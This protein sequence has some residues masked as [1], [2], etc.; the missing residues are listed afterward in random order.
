M[1]TYIEQLK[2]KYS[3]P[4]QAY[5]SYALS[6]TL[7]HH[8]ILSEN[9]PQEVKEIL[10]I[11]QILNNYCEN[12]IEQ[13]FPKELHE[14]FGFSDKQH[15]IDFIFTNQNFEKLHFLQISYDFRN[16]VLNGEYQKNLIEKSQNITWSRLENLILQEN[17]NNLKIEDTNTINTKLNNI[18]KDFSLAS[19]TVANIKLE[20]PFLDEI[21]KSLEQLSVA[22]SC[23]KKH[24]GL[25]K[26][27]LCIDNGNEMDLHT[28][29]IGR[30]KSKHLTLYIN[31]RVMNEVIAHEWFHFLDIVTAEQKYLD[32]YGED[33]DKYR[34]MESKLSSSF[35][36]LGNKSASKINNLP[37]SFNEDA[38]YSSIEQTINKY[39]KLNKLKN[40]EQLKE[41]IKKE[42]ATQ[43]FN[44]DKI[45]EQ[46]KEF[47][48]NQKTGFISYILSDMDMLKYE[49][50]LDT[51]VL[52]YYNN[53]MDNHMK[54]A[55][56]LH[57]DDFYSMDLSEISARIFESYVEYKLKEKN[58]P[59]I[60]SDPH[61]FHSPQENELKFYI[62]DLEKIINN[63]K[64]YFNA[65]YPVSNKDVIVDKIL[66][67]P[68]KTE[69]DETKQQ[70]TKNRMK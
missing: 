14:F 15:L 18:V 30:F 66:H 61:F 29:A 25:N 38:V 10:D 28:G 48:T 20:E 33:I 36:I 65:I 42:L 1:K 26:M 7:L 59:N 51:S 47:Q 21:Y 39:N 55:G 16:L 17:N 6:K 9:A 56:L 43:N 3:S 69:A 54:K 62:N 11:Q 13:S 67:I 45:I 37:M 19:I 44:Y 35:R 27:H 22:L 60:I 64:Q 41:F 49:S 52:S 53:C 70:S 63:M 5:L 57:P 68:N 58:I 24:V 34:L 23:D 40:T 12:F 50:N 32:I 31:S 8:V 2:A 46:L 4:K